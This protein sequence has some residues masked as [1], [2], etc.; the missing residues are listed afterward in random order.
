MH[1]EMHREYDPGALELAKALSSSLGCLLLQ[2]TVTRLLVDVNR[3]PHNPRRF[4]DALRGLDAEER[5]RIAM[6]YYLPYRQSVRAAVDSIIRAGRRALHLSVHTFAPTLGGRTRKADIGLLYDPKRR[7][8]VELCMRWRMALLSIRGSL[9]IRR[10]YP[11]KGTS[12]GMTSFLRKLYCEGNYV[13]IEVEVNQKYPVGER[14]VWRKL[15]GDMVLSL[16]GVLNHPR[17]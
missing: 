2:S 14:A 10:N 15:M 17:G 12:D 8:E 4:A 13:G 5:D 16:Q 7:S 3:S 6:L 9:R 11:Y 1:L